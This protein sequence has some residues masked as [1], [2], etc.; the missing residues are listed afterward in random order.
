[1]LNKKYLNDHTNRIHTFDSF[2]RAIV[3]QLMNAAVKQLGD[4][5]AEVVNIDMKFTIEAFEPKTCV[6]ICG[7]YE[8]VTV[9]Y[10]AEL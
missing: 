1:M 5:E 10:H 4:K 8:G 9:C 6:K 7:T 2:G 3:E